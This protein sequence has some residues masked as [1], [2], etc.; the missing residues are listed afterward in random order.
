MAW[1]CVGMTEIAASLTLTTD[2][3]YRGYTKTQKDPAV[4]IGVEYVHEFD[5][6][7]DTSFFVGFWGS[8]IA[9]P[10]IKIGGVTVA[11][12]PANL[13]M[14]PYIGF[15]QR[16]DDDWYTDVTYVRY[17]FNEDI[18][19]LD[20]DYN[21]VYVSLHYQDF[22][23]VSV[24]SSFN[25]GVG[26]DGLTYEAQG[27]YPWPYGIETSTTLGFN[28]G[29]K[30]IGEDYFYWNVGVTKALGNFSFDLRYHD[31]NANRLFGNNTSTVNE[32]VFSISATYGQ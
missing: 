9:F 19:G 21:E 25:Y 20:P 8:N 28:N 17:I 31:G 27:R 32:V 13:E 12:S 29:Q 26:E 1:P 24:A 2:Y 6:L 30:A 22:L 3:V 10:D 23:S 4:Q 16:L 15:S 5:I 11:K 14:T 7:S 18:F